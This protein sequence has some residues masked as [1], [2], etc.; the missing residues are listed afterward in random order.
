MSEHIRQR[1]A[2]DELRDLSRFG[3]FMPV[4]LIVGLVALAI[5]IVV[6]WGDGTRLG[7]AYL[8]GYAAFLTIS[9]GALFFV[10]IQHL[11]R[12]GW[13]VTVRRLAECMAMNLWT[14][15]LLFIPIIFALPS[16]YRWADAEYVAH[17]TVLQEKAVWLNPTFWTLRHLLLWLGAPALMA[18][19]Y[20][21]N[22]L[23]Q[24]RTGEPAITEKLQHNAGLMVVIFGLAVNFGL[25][26]LLMTLDPH[27]PSTMFGVY[28]FAGAFLNF[29]AWSILIFRFLQWRG[30]I[31]RSVTIEHYHDMGKFMFAFVFFWSYIAFSQWMLIWYANM[32]EETSWFAKRGATT[33]DVWAPGVWGNVALVLLFGHC[34][35]PFAGLMSRWSKR[36]LGLLTFWAAWMAVMHFVD[37]FWIV[38]PEATTDLDDTA[39]NPGF[40][41]GLLLALLCWIGVG[42]IWLSSLVWFARQG[43]LV[44]VQDPRL[45]EAISYEVY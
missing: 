22:S 8:T 32:P 43:S 26:D 31:T 19:W 27:W 17:D 29:F 39:V 42:C 33:D 44:P 25:I 10:I 41:E 11:T 3:L 12:A 45:P 23:R 24:D 38:M 4:L 16:I 20:W 30:V 7:M 37:M 15:L 13:S 40:G 18:L 34:L 28:G 9:F 6:G 1:E 14:M 35:I 5:A 2:G 21:R 36:L